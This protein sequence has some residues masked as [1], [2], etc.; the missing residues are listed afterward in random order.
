M[1]L[2]TLGAFFMF[3]LTVMELKFHMSYRRVRKILYTLY[4]EHLHMYKTYFNMSNITR[5]ILFKGL[6]TKNYHDWFL[7]FLL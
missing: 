7:T 5:L 3:V 6:V 1:V 4:K 2:N